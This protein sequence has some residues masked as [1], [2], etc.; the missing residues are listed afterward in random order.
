[1]NSNCPSGEWNFKNVL[2]CFRANVCWQ[3]Q[4]PRHRASSRGGGREQWEWPPSPRP[5][6][7]NPFSVENWKTEMKLGLCAFYCPHEP[8]IPN[9]VSN[10]NY[11]QCLWENTPP[12]SC[13][14]FIFTAIFGSGIWLKIY[15][16][17]IL[18]SVPGFCEHCTHFLPF[19]NLLV[20][21][22]KGFNNCQVSFDGNCQY[23]FR[24]W[25]ILGRY[26]TGTHIRMCIC[27]LK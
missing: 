14:L 1:M 26:S 9:N 6:P 27:S 10:K 17:L 13:F 20:T 3:Y 5:S 4:H 24:W 25:H 15:R 23:G 21:L 19:I 7:G 11:K 12:L 22:I 8:K 16:S 2:L 18:R